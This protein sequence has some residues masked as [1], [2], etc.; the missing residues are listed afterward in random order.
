MADKREQRGASSPHLWVSSTYFAEGF[1]YSVVHQ[2]A[3][4]LFKEAGASLQA[5]GL[6]ALFH[7]PWNLKFLWGPLL[8]AFSTKRAWMVGTEMAIVVVLAG[9]AVVSPMPAVLTL[10]SVLFVV[11]AVLAATHDV[12]ID[13]YYLEALDTEGQSRFVGYRATAYKIAM[14]VV[15]GPLL[16]M[17]GRT[18]WVIGF[19]ATAAIMLLLLGY[20]AAF[21]PRVERPRQPFAVLVRASARPRALVGGAL[22]VGIVLI[23]RQLLPALQ[24]RLPLALQRISA[25]EWIA[26]GLLASLLVALSGLPRIR[27]RLEGRDS[28]YANAFVSFL[29]QAQVGRI[30]AFVILF[31]AGESFLLKMR[32]PFLRDTGMT[33][34]QFAFASGT[35]GLIA[36]FVATLLGGYLISRDGLRRWIWPFVLAQ[37]ALNLLYLGLARADA[38]GL[39]ALT[40]VISVEA[41]GAGLGTA[42]FM[43]YLMRCCR[44]EHRAAHMA[45]LTALMSLSFT[46]AGV[47]SGFLAEAMGFANYFGFTFLA[48]IPA[49]ALVPFLPHVDGP[50][51]TAPRA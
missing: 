22:V 8:D 25:A 18:G 9:L 19:L 26:L 46:L 38:P 51:A 15:A 1:P 16:W 21:L 50:P 34:E 35:V 32:Y 12:A 11:L 6:T 47:A 7:L 13:G 27:S 45:L 4:V 20:H 30:L 24:A 31:R 14:M 39:L 33:M 48:T 41:F 5:I 29:E 36:S 44:P 49:M 40:T 42:V 10:A 37:N 3:E 23:A 17:I 43:V 2:L 28:F